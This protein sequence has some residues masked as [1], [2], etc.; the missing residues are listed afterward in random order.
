M[1]HNHKTIFKRILKEDFFKD[2]SLNT[3]AIIYKLS[4]K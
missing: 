2:M 3:Y 1:C 4:E